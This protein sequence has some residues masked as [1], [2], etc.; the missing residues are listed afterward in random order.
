MATLRRKSS[1]FRRLSSFAL[2]L[3]LLALVLQVIEARR[4]GDGDAAKGLFLS[5]AAPL[6][7]LGS[8]LREGT[9]NVW[10]SLRGTAELREE[11]DRLRKEL[12]EAG[13]D[14]QRTISEEAL[15]SLS[16]EVS[17]N[18]PRGTW[19]IIP[20]PVLRGPLSGGRQVLWLGKGTSD[21]LSAGMVALGPRGIVGVIEEARESISL[22]KLLTD[23]RATWGAE[24]EERR[25]LGLL[26]GTGDPQRV[27]FH[28]NRTAISAQA[29]DTVTSSG[30]GGS[31]APGGVLFGVVE[32]IVHNR[33]GEPVAIVRLPGEPARLRTVFILP[34]ERVPEAPGR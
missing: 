26:R 16:H 27:E 28:F 31:L 18:I 4:P 32:E 3:L 19:D 9:G 23:S 25:E 1:R 8:A 34:L 2:A 12:L 10:T 15:A 14:R 5:A 33:T 24:I 20:V 6:L 22:V 21:G 11:N 29:G 13:L 17:T 30:M 7:Q